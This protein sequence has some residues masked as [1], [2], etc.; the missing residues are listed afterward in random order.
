[1]TNDEEQFRS[2]MLFQTPP[3]RG[4]IRIPPFS[5][6]YLPEPCV[7]WYSSVNISYPPLFLTVRGWHETAI[8]TLHV[9]LL[10][11]EGY[12]INNGE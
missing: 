3:L 11:R 4:S 9:C 12:I 10:R 5:I 7:D 8:P 1:M 2:R 6:T